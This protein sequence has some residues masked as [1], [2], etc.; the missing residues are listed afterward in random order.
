[1]NFSRLRTASPLISLALL[2]LNFAACGSQ[3]SEPEKGLVIL[4]VGVD[5]LY[6]GVQPVARQEFYLLDSDITNL[7]DDTTNQ[8]NLKLSALTAFVQGHGFEAKRHKL[9]EIIQ[10]H[11]VAK[12]T[13]DLQGKLTFAPI[14]PGAYYIMGW[15]RTRKSDG[16]HELLIWNY[17]VD[18]RSGP[19]T[20][21]LSSSDAAMIAPYLPPMQSS[22]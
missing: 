18:V 21:S 22:P 17:K 4:E 16:F 7:L 5:Y 2:V 14:S 11:T 10:Q 3:K 6:G 19:Q 12:N 20:V 8:P 9:T 13:T 1:M 15:S